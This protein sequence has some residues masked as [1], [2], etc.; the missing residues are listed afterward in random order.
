MSQ[1][2]SKRYITLA[3][4]DPA[5]RELLKRQLEKAGYAVDACENGRAALDSLQRNNGGIVLADWMMPE[6][7][8]V[9]LARTVRELNTMQALPFVYFVLLTAHSE[10]AQIVAGLEAGA[11]DYLTKP[12]HLQELL[13]R[14]R[15]GE[16][17]Y[18][19]QRQLVKR[20]MELHRANAEMA[21]LNLKLEKIANTD[22]LTGLANRRVLFE[23]LTE[24]WSHSVRRDIPL[25][26]IMLDV[27]R[28]KRINDSHGHA[29]GDDVLKSVAAVCRGAARAHDV[30]ARFGGEEFCLL[31]PDTDAAGAAQFA[32]RLRNAIESHGFTFGPT[33]I[34]VSVSIGVA[35][36][37]PNHQ[38]GEELIAAA[39]EMLYR[40]KNSGRNCTWVRTADNRFVAAAELLQ[41]A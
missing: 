11:D 22:S 6:M 27:D 2:R 14:L 32:E 20:Q 37:M 30:A 26:C 29:A 15:A 23:R 17:I 28:F 31:C 35:A 40:A 1:S 5:S 25:A 39:D 3:E 36:R 10:T 8:G 19:L 12:Y 24:F 21:A 13:A 41:P 38:C 33:P 18:E 7:D 34:P 4:D 16:R 9:T